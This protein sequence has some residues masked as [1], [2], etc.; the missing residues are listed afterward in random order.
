MPT[1]I[2]NDYD[3]TI[4]LVYIAYLSEK[5]E[6]EQMGD[7][8]NYVLNSTSNIITESQKNIYNID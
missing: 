8:I 4:A 2:I 3:M 5:K 7:S 6:Y 1:K